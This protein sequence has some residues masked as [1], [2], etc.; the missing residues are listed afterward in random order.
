M[1]NF[2]LSASLLYTLNLIAAPPAPLQ[3]HVPVVIV[4]DSGL[5][6]PGSVFLLVHGLD[7]CGLPCYLVPGTDGICSY[8]YPSVTG[9]PSSASHEVSKSLADLPTTDIGTTG[10]AYLIYMP[11]NSSSR[12]YLSIENPIYLATAFNNAPTRKVLDVND[13]SVTTIQDPNFYTWYQDFEFGLV[14]PASGIATGANLATQVFMNLSWVDYFCLPMKLAVQSYNTNA[15]I[16]GTSTP[17]SGFDPTTSRDSIMTSI[18]SWLNKGEN[19][20]WEDLVVPYY[21]NQYTATSPEGI[22]RILAAKNSIAFGTGVKFQGAAPTAT[23]AYFPDD[24]IHNSIYGPS[25]STNYMQQVYTFYAQSANFLT[26]Q[27]FPQGG[28]PDCVYSYQISAG[29]GG[30]S[31]TLTFTYNGGAP[32]MGFTQPISSTTLDLGTLTTEQL[33][34]GSLWPFSVQNNLPITNELSKLVS[35]LFSIGQLPLTAP[36]TATPPT[37]YNCVSVPAGVNFVNNNCGFSRINKISG[38][39]NSYFQNPFTMGPWFNLYDQGIHQNQLTGA[40]ISPNQVPNNPSY[41]LGYGYDYDDLLNMAGLINPL[42]QDQYGNPSDANGSPPLP[43]PYVVITLG[44]L[45]GTTPL[46]INNDTYTTATSYMGY[47]VIPYPVQIGALSAN[48]TMTVNILW[49]DTTL[50]LQTTPAPTSGVTTLP[51]IIVDSDHPFRIQFSY[52]SVTYTYNI[53]LLRQAI[54]PLSPESPYS[55]VDQGL[56]EGITFTLTPPVS[57]SHIDTL[58]IGISSVAPPWPG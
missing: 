18:K 6:T 48:S 34:S 24:Y 32:G 13:S 49:Y 53:N 9:V 41:G 14:Y 40:A 55:T 7:P 52:N 58:V 54:T 57:P 38:Q 16:V 20:V 35:A 2:S 15:Q 42:V 46:N 21:T 45:L 23:Q 26:V 29:G 10:Q 37:D 56:M 27:I 39:N 1:K 44:N 28:D 25:G 47:Q 5:N 31:Y 33:L 30:P 12:A 50:T 36:L 3:D 11:I 43:D 19:T 17:V 51:D 22:L 8:V 4:D